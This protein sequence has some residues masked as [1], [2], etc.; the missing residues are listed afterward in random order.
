MGKSKTKLGL[1]NKTKKKLP[2]II[3]KKLTIILNPQICLSSQESRK[4]S[5]V[6]VQLTETFYS[7]S[8]ISVCDCSSHSAIKRS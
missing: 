8:I 3:S 4:M 1:K 7:F 6:K 2:V 5:S